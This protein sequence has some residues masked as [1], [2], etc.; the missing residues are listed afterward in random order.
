MISMSILFQRTVIWS[1]LTI[2][3][4]PRAAF[5]VVYYLPEWFQVVKAASPTK[6]G[7]ENLPMFVSQVVST[8]I[9]VIL[10]MQ[11]GYYNSWKFSGAAL[12]AIG[13][14]LYTTL[15]LDSN[16]AHWIAYQVEDLALAWSGRCHS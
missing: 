10:G 3:L 15:K 13:T 7:I 2:M 12:V 5:A 9:A 11:L 16:S 1:N 6:G 14:G 8:M 4:V